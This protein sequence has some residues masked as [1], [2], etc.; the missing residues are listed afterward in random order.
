MT[1][2]TSSYDQKLEIWGKTIHLFHNYKRSNFE[3]PLKRAGF[4]EVR[5]EEQIGLTDKDGKNGNGQVDVVSSNKD[6][7]V[8]VEITVNEKSKMFAVEKY[9]RMDPNYLSNIGL[10]VPSGPPDVL[11]SRPSSIDDGDCCQMILGDYLETQKCHTIKNARLREALV[12]SNGQDLTRLPSCPF[13]LI[14]E[15]A[16][17]IDAIRKGL[18]EHV[19]QLLRSPAARKSPMEIVIDAL[20]P[21]ASKIPP[22]T[23]SM[24]V[25]KVQNEL[26]SLIAKD[27]K[28][29]LEK[30][31]EGHYRAREDFCD[32]PA[33]KKRIMMLLQ[34]WAGFQSSQKR[35]TDYVQ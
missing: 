3:G 2:I 8:V 17:D 11:T 12:A 9:R 16:N 21:L 19:I 25:E 7:W 28:Q 22:K 35:L 32:Y 31:N 5:F 1:K 4:S 18:V 24:L 15:F 27:L 10:K 29:Y 6:A 30:D 14:P 34:R 26:D 23:K 13:T 33:T 20:G